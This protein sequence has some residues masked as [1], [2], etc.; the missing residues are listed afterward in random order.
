M[1]TPSVAGEK[2]EYYSVQDNRSVKPEA[3]QMIDKTRAELMRVP[4]THP[5]A[6]RA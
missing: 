2:L 1:R 5:R 3:S 4:D 6:A